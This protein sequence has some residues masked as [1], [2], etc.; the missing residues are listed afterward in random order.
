[1]IV[2]ISRS[3]QATSSQGGQVK[4]TIPNEPTR[5]SLTAINVGRD[6]SY[7]VELTVTGPEGQTVQAELRRRP[8]H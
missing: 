5:L 3:G 8:R 4:I 6:D 7:E 1:M 2:R